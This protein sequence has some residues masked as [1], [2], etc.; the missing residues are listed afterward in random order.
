MK[1]DV[2]VQD[3]LK[4]Y[5]STQEYREKTVLGYGEN[6]TIKYT[7][8]KTFIFNK[9]LSGALSEDDKLTVI[10]LSYM[11]STLK[12]RKSNIPL[13]AVFGIGNERFGDGTW[14]ME[15][16][17]GSKNE[18]TVL[19]VNPAPPLWQD[20]GLR[21]KTAAVLTVHDMMPSMVGLV[22]GALGAFFSNLTDPFWRIRVRD[23][24]FDGIFLNCES[25]DSTLS[26]VCGKIK[27]D[28]PPTMRPA[29][30]QKGFYFS[31]FGHYL[32]LVLC[33]SELG[34]RAILELKSEQGAKLRKG[35]E[36]K[37]KTGPG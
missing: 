16:C 21:R 8:K 22:N 9:N 28:S 4:M 36:L 2:S 35:P 29:E 13:L 1:C 10:N 11:V 19:S 24:L 20:M 18:C 5:V 25:E 12:R 23:L 14:E 6:D 3:D 15:T 32:L 30:D 31:M 26:L 37:S 7:L 17:P 33:K 27:S 34:L